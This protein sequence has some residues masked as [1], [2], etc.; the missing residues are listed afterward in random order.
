MTP[1]NISRTGWYSDS[2]D[3]EKTLSKS[4]IKDTLWRVKDERV[5]FILVHKGYQSAATVLVDFDNDHLQIDKP[6]DWPG[7]S[8]IV[9]VIFR[10]KAKLMNH[11]DV[12]VISESED[13]IYTLFPSE[14]CRLQRRAFFR[15]DAPRPNEMIFTHDDMENEGFIVENVSAGGVL[16]STTKKIFLSQ[17]DIISN[18]TLSLSSRKRHNREQEKEIRLFKVM[19]GIIVRDSRDMKKHIQNYGIS[20][21]ATSLQE[22]RL[23][24]YVR[25]EELELLQKA[26]R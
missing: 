22:E 9:R 19:K 6:V 2:S 8:P 16:I 24:K 20:F 21:E 11:F 25:Q 13:T 12:K 18:L 10:D 26:G 14:L 4:I 7:T 23:L 1:A 5:F 3:Y 17:G 15:I